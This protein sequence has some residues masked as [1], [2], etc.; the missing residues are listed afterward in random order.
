MNVKN[1]GYGKL[2]EE[3]NS[4]NVN[5]RSI[6]NYHVADFS[7]SLSFIKERELE[8]MYYLVKQSIAILKPKE[9][10][11]DWV[12]KNF[13]DSSTHLTLEAIRVD[14]NSYLIPE[15]G[16]IEDG[17]NFVDDNFEELFV[18]ELSSWTD[19]ESDWPVDRTLKLFWEWFDVEVHPTIID[20]TDHEIKESHVSKMTATTIH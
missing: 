20:L 12:N 1:A 18:L 7:T 2:E 13:G 16:E 10:F 6:R 8:I 9:P 5:I 19:N 3:N 15:V 17:I 14:C 4:Q 11:L